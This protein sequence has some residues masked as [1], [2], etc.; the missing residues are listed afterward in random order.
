MFKNG[1]LYII[2]F[3]FSTFFTENTSMTNTQPN[4][5]HNTIIGTPKYV[6]YYVHCGEEYGPRD[7]MISL[8]YI[9]LYLLFGELIWE[10]PKEDTHVREPGS[11]LSEIHIE[12][13]KNIIRRDLKRLDHLLSYYSESNTLCQFFKYC[14]SLSIDHLPNYY[15]INKLFDETI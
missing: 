3:G 11:P 15:C 10:T 8:G 13:P 5:L 7:D 9:F 4:K 1:E 2:D 12:Y 14:Y 6:S